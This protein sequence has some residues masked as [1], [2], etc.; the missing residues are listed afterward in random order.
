M[1]ILF[2]GDI[3]GRPGR[4]AVKALLP[5]IIRENNVDFTIANGENLASG[6]GMTYE[7]YREMTE[8]GIDYFTTGNHIWAKKEFWPYLDDTAINVIRPANVD[9]TLPGRGSVIIEVKEKKLQLI[10][11]IGQAFMH[12][13]GTNYFDAIDEILKNSEADIR[14][15]DF[16]AEATSE[17]AILAYYLD[18]KISGLIGTHTHVQTADERILPN[19]TAFQSDVGMTG[20]IN[21]SLGAKLEPYFGAARYGQAA[22]YE[23]A[24]GPVTFNS[25]LLTFD[26]NKVTDINRI[27]QIFNN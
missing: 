16:H 8:V 23:V 20:P 10:N 3:V 2:V 26:G 7:K 1:N 25:T 9:P 5:D 24:S 19:G 14:I 22:K 27:H 18:G 15:V 4:N 11:L 17:K 6:I 12:D 21:S 13:V